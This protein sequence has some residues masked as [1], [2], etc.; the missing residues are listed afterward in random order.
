MARPVGGTHASV[1][2]RLKASDTNMTTNDGQ[3]NV[4][5]PMGECS[6]SNLFL[7]AKYLPRGRCN[8][9][10]HIPLKK[11]YEKIA[12]VRT[13]RRRHLQLLRY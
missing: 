8:M 10:C 6:T 13:L 2:L 12:L 7:F 3:Q 4:Y 1:P 5:T 9:Q 11:W